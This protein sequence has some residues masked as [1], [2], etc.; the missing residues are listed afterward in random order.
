M[1]SKSDPGSSPSHP[2]ASEIIQITGD[3][4][5]FLLLEHL[6]HNPSP[7]HWER[8]PVLHHAVVS[9]RGSAAGAGHGKPPR[10]PE[11]APRSMLVF[12][13]VT[14]GYPT[15]RGFGG[16]RGL[17]VLLKP[18]ICLFKLLPPALAIPSPKACLQKQMR[19]HRR[20]RATVLP[21]APQQAR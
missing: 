13:P 15:C 18:S 14:A 8:G 20:T 1:V 10:E 6:G 7:D 21:P 11:L 3:L 9:A 19:A 16:F 17:H 12:L 4:D 5:P 2:A